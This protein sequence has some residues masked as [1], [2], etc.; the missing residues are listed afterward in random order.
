MLTLIVFGLLLHVVME[1]P[2]PLDQ[3][4]QYIDEHQDDYVQHLKEWIAIQSESGTPT[5]RDEVIRMM[6]VVGE[7]IKRLGGTIELTDMGNEELP[8]GKIIPLPPVVLGELGKDPNKTT[9]CIYGHAD[10]QPARIND[11][12]TTDPYVLTEKNGNLYGRGSSD[13]KGPILAWLH[14][15]EAFQALKQDLP[16]NLKFIFEGMEES[17]SSGLDDLLTKKNE[18]FFS[19]VEFIVISDGAWLSKKP[20]LTYGTRGLCYFTIEVQGANQDLHSGSHGGTVHEAMTDLIALLDSL[21][22]S[23]GHIL[24][25][26]IDSDVVPLTDEEC[27]LYEP[28][29]F[30]LEAFKH[31]I[32]TSELLHKTKVD[33]LLHRWRFPSLSIHGIEGAFSGPGTKTVIPAKVKGKFSIRLVP[34][35]D[36]EKLSNQVKKYLNGVFAE[37]RTPNKLRVTLQSG[38]KAWSADVTDKQYNAGRRAIRKVFG[39]EADLIRAGGTIPIARTL[40]HTTQKSVMMLPI[41]GADD[42]IHSQNEK[43]SREIYI[44]GTKLFAAFITEISQL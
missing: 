41:G 38:S 8:S 25:P 26:G 12:W 9:V 6:H 3:V 30:N 35:M 37:R 13:D 31:I 39:I 11:G 22:N 29:E 18:T 21:V 27:L 34:N 42:G 10:V 28:I 7:T 20:A 32:G 40:Q 17:G 19:N 36:P 44:N 24:I 43:L 1:V 23:S 14:A 15:I 2:S 4:L 33:V 5:K 16:V